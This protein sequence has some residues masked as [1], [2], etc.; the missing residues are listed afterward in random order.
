[1]SER[2]WRIT[3]DPDE[4]ADWAV[5]FDDD[6]ARAADV[7]S[8]APLV[9]FVHIQKTAGKTLRQIL[10]RQYAGPGRSV[11]VPNFFAKPDL[12]WSTLD[13]LAER[14]PPGLEVAHGHMLFVPDRW[15]HDTRFVTILRDPVERTISHYYWLNE[16]RG[17]RSALG[18]IDEA[19]DQ[20]AISD[21][22]QVRVLAG[23]DPSGPVTSTMAD[24]AIAALDRFSMVGLTSR[25]DE[26]LVFLGRAFGWR[27][28]AY[29]RV[30]S[31]NSRVPRTALDAATIARIEEHNRFDLELYAAAAKRFDEL[32]RAQPDDFHI[33]VDI[34]RAAVARTPLDAPWPE[35]Q[36]LLSPDA[37]DARALL[38]AAEASRLAAELDRQRLRAATRQ[39]AQL[40]SELQSKARVPGGYLD[41]HAD[42]ALRTALTRIDQLETAQRGARQKIARARKRLGDKPTEPGTKAP[43]AA[44]E[45]GAATQP[46]R[47]TAQPKAATGARRV[48]AGG[49]AAAD[50]KKP[51][52]PR[53]ST[54]GPKSKAPRADRPK[55][56]RVR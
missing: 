10:R 41:Q 46:P 1:M 42:E 23:A 35:Q 51:K 32:V 17:A 8:G 6:E 11:H 29:E 43:S 14:L 15:P 16:R 53:D 36:L 34:V 25:F 31:T 27:T 22:L 19:I 33:E 4:D 39:I 13:E 12:F 5:G 55:R 18:S 52:R 50:K 56:T 48:D 47:P 9:V 44:V 24:E 26:T 2:P 7:G 28:A 54:T 21:N 37:I 49:S 20:G 40:Q 3:E 38:V 30:N 45:A